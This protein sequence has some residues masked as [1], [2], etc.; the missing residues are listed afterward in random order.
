MQTATLSTLQKLI[1]INSMTLLYFLKTFPMAFILISADAE[2]FLS[3]ARVAF[4][5][6]SLFVKTMKYFW[7][8][9]ANKVL[10]NFT[11]WFLKQ[12]TVAAAFLVPDVKC[13]PLSTTQCNQREKTKRA[14]NR[15]KI[16]QSQRKSGQ[17][18]ERL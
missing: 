13:D 3:C 2:V 6:C 11:V 9:E 10:R 5:P 17:E 15:L 14:E 7:N 12:I 4:C 16:M 1:F 8:P 18:K